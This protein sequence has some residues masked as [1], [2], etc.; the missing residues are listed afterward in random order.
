MTVDSRNTVIAVVDESE[1]NAELARRFMAVEVAGSLA[2]KHDA[3]MEKMPAKDNNRG[4]F[5]KIIN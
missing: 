4:H 1:A 2:R 5:W 3:I